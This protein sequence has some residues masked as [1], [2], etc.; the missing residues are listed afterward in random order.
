MAY[1]N[2][3]LTQAR[4]DLDMVAT[5]QDILAAQNDFIGGKIIPDLPVQTAFGK[6][7]YVDN[8]TWLKDPFEIV[9]PMG[10]LPRVEIDFGKKE[11]SCKR[12]G[13]EMPVNEDLCAIYKDWLDLEKYTAEAART[14]AA[15]HREASAVALY[16]NAASYGTS[17]AVTNQWTNYDNA[18][19]IADLKKLTEAI[20]LASGIDP[21]TVVMSETTWKNMLQCDEVVDQVKYITAGT[22]QYGEPTTANI[23]ALI[24]VKQILIGKTRVASESGGS[25]TFPRLWSNTQVAAFRSLESVSQANLPHWAARVVYKPGVSI[26]YGQ[27]SAGVVEQCEFYTYP[28]PRSRSEIIQ[29]LEWSDYIVADVNCAGRLTNICS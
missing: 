15:Y 4:P 25:R 27:K 14:M 20:G 18:T 11:F 3:T 19:P 17:T 6:Y 7:P 24:G 2:D 29:C 5:S 21:N 8:A 9:A 23:A 1:P 26:D 13:F 10:A 28:D 22:N 12:R 16:E